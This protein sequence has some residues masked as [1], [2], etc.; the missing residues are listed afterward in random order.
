MLG[1]VT[2]TNRWLQNLRHCDVYNSA[3]VEKPNKRDDALAKAAKA[4]RPF[5][6][7][8]RRYHNLCYMKFQSSMSHSPRKNLN[9]EKEMS[10]GAD[11][12]GRNRNV[13]PSFDN[14]DAIST[15]RV[16]SLLFNLQLFVLL[17]R[18]S[19]P[20][21][22]PNPIPCPRTAFS[23]HD[24]LTPVAGGGPRQVLDATPQLS[25]LGNVIS[26]VSALLPPCSRRLLR[27]LES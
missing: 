8:T 2:V 9:R 25:Y 19:N 20:R 27:I 26:F 12:H 3:L 7:P 22:D 21:Y 18:S 10:H 16:P 15:A 4:G 13:A 14:R 23:C 5:F 1:C 17:G 11:S 6:L 24:C